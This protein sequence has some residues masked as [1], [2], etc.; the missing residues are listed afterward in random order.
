VTRPGGEPAARFSGL[1]LPRRQPAA[2]PDR[3][4]RAI[5]D[6]ANELFLSIVTPIELQIKVS[7]GKLT[8]SKSVR[9]AVQFELDQGTFR[10]LPIA[11]EH[12]DAL[13]GL[14]A[15]HRDPFDRLLI[16]QAMHDGLTIVTADR[17]IPLYAVPTLWE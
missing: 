2:L 12:I 6:P 1:C 9:E 13:A 7:L 11:L 4:R 5:E 15:H 10:L 17:L 8:F 16:A 14:P 3:A